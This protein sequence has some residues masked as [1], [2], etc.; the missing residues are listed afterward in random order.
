[1]SEKSW[2]VAFQFCNKKVRSLYVPD[3][4]LLRDP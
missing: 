4:D 2:V 1:L 3:S